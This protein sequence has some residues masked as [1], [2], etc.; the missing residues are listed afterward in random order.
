MRVQLEMG[1][2]WKKTDVIE[3]K[4]TQLKSIFNC[5]L[6]SLDTAEDLLKCRFHK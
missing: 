6:Q 5:E 1:K 3:K 4:T 2:K